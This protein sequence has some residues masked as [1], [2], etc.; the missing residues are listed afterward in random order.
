MI[1][2]FTF[3]DMLRVLFF[4]DWVL[5]VLVLLTHNQTIFEHINFKG[6]N[7]KRDASSHKPRF[8]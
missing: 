1:T 5:I 6:D 2:H 3:I 8:S 7:K 4:R